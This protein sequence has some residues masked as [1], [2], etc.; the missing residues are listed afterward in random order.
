MSFLYVALVFT[1]LIGIHEA[2]H[3]LA[4]R[5]VG[6]KVEKFA[7]GLGPQWTWK[8]KDGTE[9]ALGAIPLGGYVRITGMDGKD[10]E[11]PGHFY[12]S[13]RW[14]Q[15]FVLLAGVLANFLLAFG[16]I[17]VMM[18]LM[19]SDPKLPPPTFLEVMSASVESTLRLIVVMMQN[20][21]DFIWNLFSF[22]ATA[23]EGYNPTEQ[24][25]GPAGIAVA[26]TEAANEGLLDL[27]WLTSLVSV[28]IAAFNLLPI[29]AL[30]G[31]RL[32]FVG[33][34]A[35]TNRPIPAKI[36]IVAS[37]AGLAFVVVIL[38][39]GTIGDIGRLL[40]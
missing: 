17:T 24:V 7:I 33:I 12:A 6:M 25:A 23:P 19:P 11:T 16:L 35:I 9:Y 5:W 10:R 38:V 39:V 4:A 14:A 27:L 36:N 15:A 37:L 30:D 32:L 31:G 29:P 18:F 40:N 3:F 1:V 2:G 20:T 22:G 8:S 26:V 21:V 13:P 34:E 28:A